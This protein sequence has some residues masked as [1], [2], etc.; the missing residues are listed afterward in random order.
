MRLKSIGKSLSILAIVACAALG[1]SRAAQATD[2]AT[3][4]LFK[5]QCSTCH[6]L[7]GR[8]QTTAGKPLG[9]KDWTDGRTLKATSDAKI[10]E[11]LRNGAKGKD[12]KQTMTPVKKGVTDEQVAALIAYVRE[13]GAGKSK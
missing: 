3:I 8:G 4:K 13:L 2:E 10:K 9:V 5:A 11:L 12:G 1:S 7:D 6:G